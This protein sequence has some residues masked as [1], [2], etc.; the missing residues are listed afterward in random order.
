MAN[1]DP[2]AEELLVTS[3]RL[4]EERAAKIGDEI[5]RRSYLENVPSNREIL[6]EFEKTH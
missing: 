4:L 3:Y 1:K 5:M 2:R 6:Q